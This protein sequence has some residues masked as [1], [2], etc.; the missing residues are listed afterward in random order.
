MLENPEKIEQLVKE[1]GAVN[2]DYQ[3]QEE[4]E[5]LT[6]KTHPY[7]DRWAP[8]A[9]ELWKEVARPKDLVNYDGR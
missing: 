2:T 4:V 3:N 9:E 1:T 8:V 7:A 6:A 5:E